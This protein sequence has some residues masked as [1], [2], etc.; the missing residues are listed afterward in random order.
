M[1]YSV[2]LELTCIT[3]LS[4]HKTFKTSKI[5]TFRI[6]DHKRKCKN[7]R[8]PLSLLQMLDA[9]YVKTLDVQ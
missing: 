4:K 9:Y 6:T 1:F 8:L 2:L 3:R 5:Q 7:P